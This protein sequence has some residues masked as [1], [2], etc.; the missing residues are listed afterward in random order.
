[1][2]TVTSAS[3]HPGDGCR[4]LYDHWRR[5]RRWLLYDHWRWLLYDHWRR[6]RRWLLY[7]H[8]LLYDHWGFFHRLRCMYDACVVSHPDWYYGCG[9]RGYV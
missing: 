1:M 6:L 7:D 3:L 2:S 8:G 9:S 5:L 4:L